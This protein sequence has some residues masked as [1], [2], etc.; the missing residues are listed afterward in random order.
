MGMA[1]QSDGY[2]GHRQGAETQAGQLKSRGMPPGRRA[3]DRN[4]DPEQRDHHI[5]R[6]LERE[7]RSVHRDSLPQRPALCERADD[8]EVQISES[9]REWNSGLTTVLLVKEFG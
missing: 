9:G 6:R 8:D 5:E 1:A 7:R 3:N 2:D 4:H